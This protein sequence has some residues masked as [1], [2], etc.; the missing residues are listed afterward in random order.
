MVDFTFTSGSY[1][2]K[3]S[4]NLNDLLRQNVVSNATLTKFW[5]G[6]PNSMTVNIRRDQN[7]QAVPGSVELSEMLPSISF[8]SSQSFPFRSGKGNDPG[9]AAALV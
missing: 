5:E 7:L 1:Y 9:G 3:T 2:Q 8:N 4:N 6:T